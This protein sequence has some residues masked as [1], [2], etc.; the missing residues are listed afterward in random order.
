[1]TLVVLFAWTGYVVRETPYLMAIPVVQMICDYMVY[2][3]R[4]EQQVHKAMVAIEALRGEV[5]AA[6]AS[7]LR[8][9]WA[10]VARIP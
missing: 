7:V 3:C 9:T 10:H 2:F 5:I 8:E 1:M 6:N 4:S